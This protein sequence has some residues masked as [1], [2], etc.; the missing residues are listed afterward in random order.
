M[1]FVVFLHLLQRGDVVIAR[2]DFL[3]SRLT[4]VYNKGLAHGDH[5]AN[6]NASPV[7]AAA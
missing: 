6:I 2:W 3:D 7:R 4:A 1:L 5:H